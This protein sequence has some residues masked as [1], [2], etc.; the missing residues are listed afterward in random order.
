M[1]DAYLLKQL[2]HP[3][4]EKR[5][6]AVMELAKTKDREALPPLAGVYRNDKDPEVR[7]LARKAGIYINKHTS[8]GNGLTAVYDDEL[9]AP[10]SKAAYYDEVDEGDDEKHV[11]DLDKERAMGLVKQALDIHMRG[12][13]DRA[14]KYL[15]DALKKDPNLKRDSY[16]TGLA[17]TITG[18]P[19]DEAVRMLTTEAVEKSKRK[20]E[21]GRISDEPTWGDAIVDLIIYMLVNMGLTA[22]AIFGFVGLLL[23]SFAQSMATSPSSAA[24]SFAPTLD[25]TV[26][27]NLLTGIGVGLVLLYS[28]IAGFVS[29]LVL[30]FQYFFIH[31]VS[32]TVL[33]GEG[34]MPRLITK[35]TLPLAFG[36][37][38][39]YLV[40]FGLSLFAATN[41]DI[42]GISTIIQFFMSIGLFVLFANRIGVAYRFGTTS[43]CAAI[44]LSTIAMFALFC[45]C[46]MILPS[47]LVSQAS[48]LAF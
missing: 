41:P 5:K 12:N 13:N 29:M 8:S 30:L 48:A 40:S 9:P 11:S 35:A 20:R 28:A 31:M 47:L 42:F 21:G 19:S 25:P 26:I 46:S 6:Q 7:E 38:V 45:A 14:V 16:T 43:G 15:R 17:A 1:I 27:L 44:V 23:P 2:N 34:T 33:S 18:L 4:S 36:Y 22:L 37:P 39:Y 3:D 10:K 24:S 32:V